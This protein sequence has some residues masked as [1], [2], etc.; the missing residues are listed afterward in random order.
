MHNPDVKVDRHL[1]ERNDTAMFGL[2]R[3]IAAPV[4]RAC[5]MSASSGRLDGYYYLYDCWIGERVPETIGGLL[6]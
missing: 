4:V 3:K 1:E 6:S 5:I 2:K